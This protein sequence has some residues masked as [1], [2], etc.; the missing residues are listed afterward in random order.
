MKRCLIL[1]LLD[2]AAVTPAVA[3][4][5]TSSSDRSCFRGRPLGEC[6]SFWITETSYSVRLSSVDR[7]ASFEPGRWLLPTAE[8]G[9]MR[10]LSGRVAVGATIGAGFLGGFYLAAKPRARVWLSRKHRSTCRPE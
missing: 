10:N 8:L 2:L 3:Q 7:Q 1:L 5:E 4:A 6:R 9:G